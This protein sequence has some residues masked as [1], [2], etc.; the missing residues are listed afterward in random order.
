MISE[1]DDINYRLYCVPPTGILSLYVIAVQWDNSDGVDDGGASQKLVVV[2]R[3][4][5][6]VVGH[7]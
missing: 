6:T 3:R 2:R 1:F 5:L 7:W 4:T